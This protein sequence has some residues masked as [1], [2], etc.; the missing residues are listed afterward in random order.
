LSQIYLLS[1]QSIDDKDIIHL[2]IFEIT[3]LNIDIDLS[4]YDALI[5]TSKNA[6]ES[7]NNTN[8]QWKDIPS[9]A[10]S[11]KTAK[12]LQSVDSNCVFN[13]KA[14]DGNEFANKLISQL[15]DK[16][17]LYIRAK[18]VVS[19]LENILKDG[20]ILCDSIVAYETSCNSYSLSKKPPKDSVIIFSSPSS[21]D[22]FC[23]NFTLDETYKI[24]VIGE[25]TAKKLPSNIAYKIA[26]EKSLASCIKI[27]KTLI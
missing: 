18:E 8:L 4:N 22:C 10:I 21:V 17:V 3:L 6:V 25:T 20:L 7:I 14:K 2:P 5:F 11:D 9:Y 23:K 1:S 26:E 16:K 27:A 19:N 12:K 13:A 24:V 15:Q